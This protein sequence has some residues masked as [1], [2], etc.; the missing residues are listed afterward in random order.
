[1]W[2]YRAQLIG[3]LDGDTVRV[4]ADLGFGTRAE[5]DVRLVGASAP[6]RAQPGGRETRDWTC[7]W[8][9]D[10]LRGDRRWPLLVR[11]ESTRSAEP[12][13]RRSLNRYLGVI[14]ACGPGCEPD[15]PSLN[16]QLRTFLAGHPEWGAGR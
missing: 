15:G 2:S 3:V 16:E 7:A 4:L 12:T 6:E 14:W 1:M 10:A 5:V 9:A 11:T 13:E 8:I